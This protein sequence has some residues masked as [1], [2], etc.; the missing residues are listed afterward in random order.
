MVIINRSSDKISE[1]MWLDIFSGGEEFFNYDTKE[2]LGKDERPIAK[3]K[4]KKVEPKIFYAKVIYGDVSKISK[5]LICR[6]GKAK[7]GYRLLFHARQSRE[8]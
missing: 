1:G 8:K 6:V 4:V 3:V 7:K 5:G 2:S